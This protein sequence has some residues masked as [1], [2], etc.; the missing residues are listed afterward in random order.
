MAAILNR[1]KRGLW[2]ETTLPNLVLQHTLL[3][4]KFWNIFAV[5]VLLNFLLSFLL[6]RLQQLLHALAQICWLHLQWLHES[7]IKWMSA[8]I[9]KTWYQTPQNISVNSMTLKDCIS[10]AQAAYPAAA[11]YQP[12]LFFHF[13]KTSLKY[14]LPPFFLCQR[15][16][17]LNDNLMW[18]TPGQVLLTAS[19]LVINLLLA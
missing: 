15:N 16:T 18:D 2:W 17:G 19:K 11:G 12:A 1:L 4:G 10:Q 8:E 14:V 5:K 3:R 7:P 13:C 6:L 9:T